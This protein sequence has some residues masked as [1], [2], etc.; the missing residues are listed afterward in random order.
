M[1]YRQRHSSRWWVQFFFQPKTSL[2]S[3]L[4]APTWLSEKRWKCSLLKSAKSPQKMIGTKCLPHNGTSKMTPNCLHL[5][6]ISPPTNHI[7]NLTYS[8]AF[9]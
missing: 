7:V 1:K 5:L 6:L 9:L 4:T 8:F 3:R 2:F